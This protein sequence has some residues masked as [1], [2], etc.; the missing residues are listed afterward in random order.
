MAVMGLWLLVVLLVI[1]SFRPIK[2]EASTLMMPV[3]G[4]LLFS[5]VLGF[6]QWHLNGGGID[7]IF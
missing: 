2:L 7:S 1:R 3:A 6:A 5:F 4:W